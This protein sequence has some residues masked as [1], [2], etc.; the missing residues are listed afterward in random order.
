[1]ALLS[2]GVEVTIIDE[3]FYDSSTPGSIPLIVVATASNKTA[4]SGSGI[5]PMTT[6][7]KAGKLFLATS[8]R[9]LVQAFGN[10]IFYSSGG[11]SLHGYELNEYGLHAAYSFL[12]VSNQA[13]ILRADV[14]TADLIPN[15]TAPTG[16]PV[17]GTYWFDVA[18]T[19]F[20]L[21]QSNG[22]AVPGKAWVSKSVKIAT[23]ADTVQQTV[24]TVSMFVPKAGFGVDGDFAVSVQDT[25]NFIF[26]KLAGAWHKI[27]STSWKAAHPTVVRGKVSPDAVVAGNT[28]TITAN[29]K[30]ATVTL[31]G[32]AGTGAVSDINDAIASATMTGVTASLSA[33]AVI[34]TN[35]TGGN[36]TIGIG[37]G[38]PLVSLGITAQTY[39]GV[40]VRFTND[41][42]YPANS[43]VVDLWVKGTSTNNG[44]DYSLKVYNAVTGV[45]EKVAVAFHPF[46]STVSDGTAGKDAAAVT[47]KLNSLGMVYVGYDATNGVIQFRR[48]NGTNFVALSY[49]ASENVPTTLPAAGTL[50]FSNDFRVDIMVSD[51]SNYL[52]YLNYYPETN[53]EGVFVQGSVPSVQS[54]GTPLVDNDLWVDTT[55]LENYPRLRRY[56][57]ATQRWALVDVTDQTSPFG[58]IFADARQDSGVAFEGQEVTGYAYNSEL[59]EDLLLSDYVDPDAPDARTV[60]AGMLLFNTRYSTYNVKEWRPEYFGYGGWDVDTDYSL[61][62]YTVGGHS[63]T[64]PRLDDKGRWVTVSG[65]RHNG[66]PLMGRRAQRAMITKAM[67]EAVIASDEA[68]SEI[69][70]FNLISAPGYPE[71]IDEL[72]SLNTDQKNTA[73]IVGDTPA[74]LAPNATEI[75]NWAANAYGAAS[76]GED[77]LTTY[78]P[79][80]GI[81]Y[82]WGL[83][84]N[85]D[86]SEI[87]VPPSTM[88]LRVMAYNDQVAYPWFAP[89]GFQRGLVS[90]ASSVG[91][92]TSEGEYQTVILNEGLRD[93]LY[94]KAINPIAYIANRGLVVFGQKTRSSL[95]TAMDRVNVARLCN[96]MAT[97]LDGIAKPFL[98]QQNDQQTRDAFKAA[99]ERF[100][101]GLVG[102]RAIE[103][104]AVQVDEENNT[105]ERIN[106]SEMWADI[107]ILPMKSIEFIYIPIRLTNDTI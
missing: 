40:Q 75:Q 32:G 80:V 101:S 54:D 35:A 102:L 55:D 59:Q 85:V 97:A 103:D 22:N 64:F 21:F 39:N 88:A 98:F 19:L 33:G 8:Q 67:A 70:N 52:G 14:D 96:Y 10:P 58:V 100:L 29:G 28:F 78:D 4:P 15:S 104:F 17:N 106:R 12:G 2:P 84:T 49:E 105:R 16:A 61:N 72:V 62:E 92:L 68:R 73:F 36:I 60:P 89:A 87:M 63:Y 82:P 86:G 42:S 56:D 51:G 99:L 95:S 13:Y 1:M 50:W 11:S 91:Y 69:I 37:T 47:A 20:G 46:T 90:N 7:S 76:N 79:Y 41:A 57:A 38:T 34:I 53:P 25:N 30:T 9:E 93:T 66:S 65:N 23:A 74:R 45:W 43:V 18:A 77:G 27:G 24:D 26:E 31:T 83:S 6:A 3:S 48:H 5:A 44:A 94:S 107:A 71:L 81:Y